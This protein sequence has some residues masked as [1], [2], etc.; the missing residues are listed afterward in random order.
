MQQAAIVSIG[1]ELILGQT[2]DT[3]S[4]YAAGELTSLGYV[5]NEHCTLPDD[6]AAIAEALLRLCAR[7]ALVIV[8]GGLGP[9]ADDLTRQA[10]ARA[11]GE[12]LVVDE[13]SLAL[14]EA[15]Y[16]GRG[17]AMPEPNRVQALR[18]VSSRMIDNDNG[19]APGVAAMVGRCHVLCFPGPPRELRPMLAR[20]LALLPA[21]GGSVTTR[22]LGTFGLGESVVA[23][24]LGAQMN[25]DRNPLVGTTASG[26][27]VS[28]RLR[29]TGH[30]GDGEA[31]LDE[32]EAAVRE[33]LGPVV[34][35]RERS[36]AEHVLSRLAACGET[37]AVVESCT[38]GLLAAGLTEVPGASAVFLGGLL[39]YSNDLKMHLAD[40]DAA[41]LEE[42]GA[43]SEACSLAMAE[44]ARRRTHATHAVS[45]T[46][47]AGPGGGSEA[48][49]VGTVWIGLASARQQTIAA[50]FRFPGERASVRM[51]SVVSGLGLLRCRLD[52][53][54][55][56]MLFR[57]SMSH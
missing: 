26:G 54:E 35:A 2:L 41:L 11:M 7:C 5:V 12:A 43:V 1:D 25:R 21:P 27:I 30:S 42:H 14:I 44:G 36:L 49:P 8:T 47:I 20:E 15:W 6:E 4:R 51:W 19:T 9:T 56:P 39:T 28:V 48:K 45:V 23:E 52:G 57:Q 17:R 22:V 40:V 13:R 33:A 34:F 32:A 24:R 29:W 16:A 53:V 10:L 46:G 50:Q 31:A 18:P 3:N 37:L 38:G 55:T